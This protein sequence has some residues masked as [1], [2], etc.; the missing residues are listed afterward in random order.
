M[1]TDLDL[2]KP[3]PI[4]IEGKLD[5][6]RVGTEVKP[7]IE[8]LYNKAS[9]IDKFEVGRSVGGKK[10]SRKKAVEILAVFNSDYGKRRAFWED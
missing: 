6:Y 7:I 8:E 4:S 1:L 10:G 5:S 9:F 2:I 3:M